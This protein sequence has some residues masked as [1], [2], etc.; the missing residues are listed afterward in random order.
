MTKNVDWDPAK[1]QYSDMV[2]E[3]GP[4]EAKLAD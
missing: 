4:R 1:A 3:L 2:L